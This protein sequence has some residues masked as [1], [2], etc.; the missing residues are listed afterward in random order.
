[1]K[2]TV[3]FLGIMKEYTGQETVAFDFSGKATYGDLMRSIG[4]R[5][6]GLLPDYIWDA[7]VNVFKDTVMAVGEGRDL[8]SPDMPLVENEEIKIMVV[9]AGG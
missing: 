9:F 5:F 1:M 8:R 6:R 4:Q 7:K 3:F 2:V